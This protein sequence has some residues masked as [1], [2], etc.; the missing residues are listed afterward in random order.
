[1]DIDEADWEIM[2]ETHIH[3]FDSFYSVFL[4]YS[5]WVCED[6]NDDSVCDEADWLIY[7]N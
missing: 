3:N 5:E 4:P 7:K 6:L 2:K 1:M